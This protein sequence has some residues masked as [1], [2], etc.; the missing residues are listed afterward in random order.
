ML[1]VA[2]LRAHLGATGLLAVRLLIPQVAQ[3]VMR[4]VPQLRTLGCT[5]EQI[6][7]ELKGGIEIPAE[8]DWLEPDGVQEPQIAV[9]QL[10]GS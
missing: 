10:V 2:Y 6:L 3:A 5:P 9:A 8:I 4:D 1:H 7:Q